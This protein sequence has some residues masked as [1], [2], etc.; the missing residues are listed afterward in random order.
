[1]TDSISMT[2]VVGDPVAEPWAVDVVSSTDDES[3]VRAAVETGLDGV[4][5]LTEDLVAGDVDVF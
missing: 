2:R 5:N 3:T 4:G 1:M